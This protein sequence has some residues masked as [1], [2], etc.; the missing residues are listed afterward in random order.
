M[1]FK[2]KLPKALCSNIFRDANLKDTKRLLPIGSEAFWVMASQ[3]GNALGSILS[4]KLLT[5]LLKPSDFGKLAVA[6]TIILLITMNIYG[7]V[8]QGL[9]RFWSISV[10][11]GQL[12]QYE[13]I[14][15]GTLRLL[16]VIVLFL[17]I[18]GYLVIRLTKLR[19][20][21]L[22]FLL[23][24]ITGALAGWFN[25]RC[26]IL[27]ADRKRKAVA[28]YNI[29]M[30][31]LKPALAGFLILLFYSDVNL[32]IVGFLAAAFLLSIAIEK[33]FVSFMRQR[34]SECALS[35]ADTDN[36][37]RQLLKA[38]LK[39]S[40]PFAVWGGFSW[41][42]QSIDKWVIQLFYGSAIVGNYAVISQLALY[43]LVFGANFLSLMF[44]PIAY[45]RA[46]TLNSQ[47]SVKSATRIV[48][49]MTF[50]YIIGA[51]LLIVV[52][53]FFNRQLVLLISNESYLELAY[54]LPWLCAA[55]AMF[56]LGQML[57]GFGLLM[58]K[59][60]M[61]VIPIIV[62]G[63]VAVLLVAYLSAKVGI[64]GVIWG[65]GIAGCLYALWFLYI[66]IKLTRTRFEAAG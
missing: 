12:T 14:T 32:V 55:W 18:I 46:G 19:Q 9:M 16:F 38:I 60:N 47:I 27:V 57:S 10:N 35:S 33:Y 13:K 49:L 65:L 54:L 28:V 61:Y 24:L 48:S 39:Y 4:I 51:L 52:F 36:D 64:S 15:Q 50:V 63:M 43:P 42:H 22:I 3:V 41:M 20:W 7:P 40:W 29:L 56:Y 34:C 23:S 58:Q 25:A 30:A 45:S 5:Y 11:K 17:S 31:F 26:S 2:F 59:P 6:N 62:C 66:A 1:N 53:K 44:L 21:A 8:G 37:T